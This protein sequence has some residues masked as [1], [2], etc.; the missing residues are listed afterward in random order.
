VIFPLLVR[1]GW[2]MLGLMLASDGHFRA[3]GAALES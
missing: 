2:A 1:A 3:S